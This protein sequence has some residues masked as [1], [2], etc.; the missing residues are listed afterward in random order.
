MRT[1]YLCFVGDSLMQNYTYHSHNNSQGVFDGR[2]SAEEMIAKA[3]EI[4][5][6]A[7]GVS[8]HLCVHP[9]MTKTHRMFFSDFDKALD[10]YKKSYAEIDE[11]AARH[12]IKVLKGFEV[13][14]FPS[15]RWRDWF[16]K[17]IRQLDYDY[18]IGATHF[19]CSADEQRICN[20]FHLNTL[21]PISPEEFDE[22]LHGYW[23]NVLGAINSGYFNFIAHFDYCT[24]FNLCNDE[25]WD[26]VK[27]QVIE[28][29]SARRLPFEINTGGFDK[30]GRPFPEW[31]WTTEL[32]K[33]NVPIVLSCDSH[34]PEQIGRHFAEAE[35]FLRRQGSVNRLKLHK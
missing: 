14:Y 27:W 12:K 4:G 20:I 25:T 31:R 11:A 23:N 10:I 28:A 33:R 24:Q 1:G 18:L 3:E 13:D 6:E 26:D 29:L 32:L 15:A 5:F 34:M 9:N 8:N 21:P 35:D 30:I 2:C 7:I 22:M 17:I 16:E 19:I